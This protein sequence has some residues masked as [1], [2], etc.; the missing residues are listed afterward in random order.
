MKQ[1]GYF[2]YN[3]VE[4]GHTFCHTIQS[5][6]TVLAS[7]AVHCNIVLLQKGKQTSETFK[8]E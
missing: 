7:D 4:S 2:I 8:F 1:N 6:G 3:N 5:S